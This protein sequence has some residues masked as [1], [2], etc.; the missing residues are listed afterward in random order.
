MIEWINDYIDKVKRFPSKY[1]KNI[2]NQCRLIS[3]LLK[4][5]DKTFQMQ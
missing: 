5:N 4:R 1:N 2:K 3:E